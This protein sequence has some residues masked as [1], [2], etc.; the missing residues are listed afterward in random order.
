MMVKMP[1]GSRCT[2]TGETG[3]LFE[4]E[5]PALAVR[6]HPNVAK[7]PDAG[8]ALVMQKAENQATAPPNQPNARVVWSRS[9]EFREKK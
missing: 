9:A 6:E 8:A 1:N 7:G 3:N 2:S 4:A 5:L